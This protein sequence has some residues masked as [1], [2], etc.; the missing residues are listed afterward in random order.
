MATRPAMSAVRHSV[1]RRLGA[2]ALGMP[3]MPPTSRSAGSLVRRAAIVNCSH[4]MPA[5]HGSPGVDFRRHFSR[6]STPGRP[7]DRGAE[8][9]EEK[10]AGGAKRKA[11]E[12]GD[13]PKEEQE[14]STSSGSGGRG[15]AMA[16]LGMTGFGLSMVLRNPATARM[17]RVAGPGGMALGLLLSVYDVGGWKLILAIPLAVAGYSGAGYAFDVSKEQQLKGELAAEL[18][19]ACPELPADIAEVIQ[20]AGGCECETNKFRL[21]TE[22]QATKDGPH[23]RITCAATRPSRF[24]P[25]SISSIEASS[26]HIELASPRGDGVPPPQTRVWDSASRGPVRWQVLWQR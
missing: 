12:Q 5:L 17:L 6:Q 26:G 11:S 25:W 9:E 22:W 15:E 18:R 2:A 3:P 8:A 21:Q 14:A 4:R 19:E 10:A 16:L 20:N 23:W 7:T 13:A 1:G 24:Q